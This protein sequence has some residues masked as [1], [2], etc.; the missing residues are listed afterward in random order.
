VNKLTL[1]K[2]E[3]GFERLLAVLSCGYKSYM[4]ME[5]LG[6]NL[7][8]DVF[9]EDYMT[10]PTTADASVD[11]NSNVSDKSVIGYGFE[12]PK[13]YFKLYSMYVLW[14][15]LKELYGLETA[16]QA[17]EKHVNGD[18]Y[19]HDLHSIAGFKPYCFNFSTYDVMLKGL[20]MINKI[21]SVRPKHFY[22]FKSQIE[23]F[24]IIAGNT[25]AGAVGLADFLIVSSYYIENIIEDLQD[26]HFKFASE[27]DAWA[28]IK[29]TFT[30]F[31][32]T[33]NQPTRASQSIFS[34]VSVYDTPNLEEL[35]ADYIF[36]GGRLLDIELVQ[37]V[38][39]VFLECMNET[40]RRTPAT[41]PVITACLTVDDE[42][43]IADETF[44][45]DMAEL[46]QEFGFINF[47]N[48][49]TSTL[50]SCCFLGEQEADVLDE[51][52]A[53]Y[54]PF[55]EL[56]SVIG[57]DG[58][59]KVAVE[60]GYEEAVLVKLPKENKGIYE[61]ITENE[62]V[63]KCT[64]DHIHLL[65]DDQ[66]KTTTELVIGDK[67]TTLDSE[68]N[69]YFEEI[70]NIKEITTEDEFVYCFEMS[71]KYNPYFSLAN[72]I[73]T[74]NCRL[75][76]ET[77]HEFFNS[78]GAGKSKIGSI[79]V[80]TMNLP[81]YAYE[82]HRSKDM[83]AAFKDKVKK[84]FKLASEINHAKRMIVKDA[85]DAGIHPLYE[86]GFME[87]DKQYST[88]GVNGLYEAIEALG[89]D[90]VSPEGTKF[91]VELMEQLNRWIEDEENNRKFPHNVEQIPAESM[92]VKAA[93]K[94]RM[95]G[96]QDEYNLYSNQFIPLTAKTDVLN[97][98][99]LQGQLDKH[100]SGGSVLHLNIGQ[101]LSVEATVKLM[102]I[103][104]NQ[105]V[106][107]WAANYVLKECSDGH[108]TAGNG[109]TCDICGKEIVNEYTRV[110][111]FLVNTK[112]FSKARREHDYPNREWYQDKEVI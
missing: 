10:A 47:F 18:I 90:I 71:D 7:N 63:L 22:S 15:K 55:K 8:P 65:I 67:L 106:V 41:F 40:L 86:F 77:S 51:D 66:E 69:V 32:Y 39:K 110:V 30:S 1:T 36:P 93:T 103:C 54:I 76:S 72:G 78:F 50:S 9:T 17:I 80:V 19:I 81:R 75:R 88:V 43:N 6:Q 97:R 57:K 64:D 70:I 31:I 84:H 11:P 112:N 61:I 60:E 100:F 34:N 105:G 52:G 109:N 42:G 13:G 101:P 87:L 2:F 29:E 99:H 96:Y 89:M 79:G 85:I 68:N 91:T 25:I 14:K 73:I 92:A 4:E 45:K 33:M 94:D 20:P 12:M 23:Q 35:K 44:A 82:A 37:K 102:K 46:N 62:K 104:A 38:Q 24:S 111:G 58:K 48:G 59:I 53:Y 98:I 28:Y 108:L 16:N 27:E 5:G 56:E 107:Y 95:A 74:H 83:R 49:K 21:K 26:A 3:P